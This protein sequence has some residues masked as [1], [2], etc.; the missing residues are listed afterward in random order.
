[1]NEMNETDLCFMPAHEMA[2]KV[3][4]QEVT[5]LEFTEALV[6]RA[7]RVN[8][9]INAY[10][11][12]TFD[13]ARAMAR[14]SDARVA[15]GEAT[16]ILNGV[17]TSIKDLVVTGGIRTTFGSKLFEDNVPAEDEVVVG[18]LREAGCVI[19]GKTNTP[20]M[21]HMAV[22]DN[23]IFGA[24]RNPWDPDRTSGGSSGGAAAA[25]AAGISPLAL[26][27]DGGGSIRIP[28][29]FCGVFGFKPSYGR[30]P[31]HP[32]E[33][34]EF[35]YL[36]H[37][38]PITRCVK[39]AAL[40]VDAVKGPHPGPRQVLPDD[41][42][43]YFEALSSGERP[44]RLKIGYWPNLGFVRAVDP[45]VEH[46]VAGAVEK[47][48]EVGWEVVDVGKRRVRSPENA[49]IYIVTAGLAHDYHKKLAKNRDAI[50]PNLV[51]LVEAGI[52]VT[53]V[54]LMAAL[55]RRETL[56]AEF[57]KFFDEY[58][59]MVTPTTAVPAFGH[60]MM[61]PPKVAG[62]SVSTLAWMSF[63]YPFNMTGLPAASLPCGFTKDGLPVGMQVVGPRWAD[64]LVL[65]AAQAFEEVAPWQDRRPPL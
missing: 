47:F 24:T 41:G 49:Y 8:P 58:D 52:G 7:E 11:T 50:S 18:R 32:H 3:K 54:D 57:R 37:Y 9:Q 60:G 35:R 27:S 44:A 53:A 38:G 1:M 61:Y 4:R 56:F 63:T 55:Y 10:C 45:E 42:V 16:G 33:G 13:L 39:D 59:L 48:S 17:P 31:R 22:T 65:Q 21:G 30:V 43:S 40:M 14:E 36:D 26:G 20:E 23:L 2:D 12:P 62:K 25:C 5:S 15:R 46:A 6:A 19:L 51:K 28:S 34:M 64:L 29:A